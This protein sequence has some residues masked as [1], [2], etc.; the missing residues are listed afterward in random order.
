ML[1]KYLV[2]AAA[3]LSTAAMAE[4]Y[5][6]GG[7]GLGHLN[8]DCSG[9]DSCDNSSTALKVA[10]GYGLNDTWSAE[11]G[12]VSFGK[13]KATL[14]GVTAEVKATAVTLAAVGKAPI[15]PSLTGLA[16]L[17][18]ANV[19]S[20]ISASGFGM[21]LNLGSETKFKPY[22]GLGLAWNLSK[23]LA[24]TADADFTQAY[25]GFDNYSVRALTLGVRASF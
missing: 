22:F 11:L 10:L 13:A 21:S 18:F 5:V 6:T 4:T 9:T 23:E 20:D 17:G 19:T 15:S 16:R 14:S 7:V 3:L 12:Y 1:K 24:V 25:D 2:I 8:E